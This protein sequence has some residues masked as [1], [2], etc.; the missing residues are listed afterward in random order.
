[1]MQVWSNDRFVAAVHRV[2][3]MRARPRYSVPFFLNPSHEARCAPLPTPD[4][5]QPHYR[6][7]EWGAFR[8]ARSD[9]DYADYG[10]EIQIADFRINRINT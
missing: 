4:A 1:M 6:E 7:I 10:K 9:G 2:R 5:D 8:Q 3:P